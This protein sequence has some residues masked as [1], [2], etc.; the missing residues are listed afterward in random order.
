[1]GKPIAE[2]LL[3]RLVEIQLPIV[4]LDGRTLGNVAYLAIDERKCN[5]EGES[6]SIGFQQ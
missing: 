6:G 3:V 1:M 4:C 2:S 5:F